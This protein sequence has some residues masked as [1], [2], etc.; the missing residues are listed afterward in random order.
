[1]TLFGDLEV[2]IL[3]ELPPT[4]KPIET[5]ACPESRV[6]TVF[7][8]VRA[9]L[10]KGRQAYIVCPLVEES[11][12]VD[13][14][15]AETLFADVRERWLPEYS[16]AI[17][18]GR[19]KTAEKD[20]TMTRF[21]EGDVKVLV[22]TTVIEVGIDV[23]NA[24]MMVIWHAERFGLAQLH[25]LRGRVGRGADQS[26]CYLVEAPPLSPEARERIDT[27]VR[28]SDGFEIAEKDLD[29]RGAGD[30][31]GTRQAGMPDFKHAN[32]ARDQEWL[33]LARQDAFALVSDDRELTKPD[34]EMVSRHYRQ[35]YL[36][37]EQLFPY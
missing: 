36:T 1:M 29:M 3:D 6:K 37:R 22:S 32:I 7:E 26:F 34:H 2:S 20:E 10:Q 17:L 4:R 25:Q 19:M 21:K 24:T 12:K 16:A 35:Q 15:D 18:H 8:S 13:L 31:F 27:M 14:L 23:P 33:K 9:E 28:T 30:F 5:K 11:E